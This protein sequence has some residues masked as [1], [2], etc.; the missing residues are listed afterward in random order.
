MSQCF[1]SKN[2]IAVPDAGEYC[3]EY[4]WEEPGKLV[5]E[6]NKWIMVHK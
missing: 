2:K 4:P 6:E 3:K 1:K 5:F